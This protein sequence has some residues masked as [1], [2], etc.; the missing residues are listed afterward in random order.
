MADI[1][2]KHLRV[3]EDQNIELIR[4]DKGLFFMLAPA[5][6]GEGFIN[7]FIGS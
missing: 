2:G 6:H 5:G 1:W 3:A 7:Y 4:E